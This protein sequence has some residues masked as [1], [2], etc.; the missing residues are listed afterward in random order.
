MK[1]NTQS[2][3][4][5]TSRFFMIGC[6]SFLSLAVSGCNLYEEGNLNSKKVQVQ[7]EA[8]SDDV[9]IALVDDAYIDALA[10]H[11]Y[12]YGGGEMNLA[13]TYDPHSNRNTAMRASEKAAEFAAKLRS[14]GVSNVKVG[15]VPVKDQ[16][17]ESRMM[18]SYMGYTAHAPE[19]CSEIPGMDGRALEYNPEYKLGCSMEAMIAQQIARPK[20]LLGQDNVDHKTDGR[21]A[22]NIVDIYRKGEQ[23]KP[24][25]GETASDEN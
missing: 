22:S 15:V 9:A 16:G 4:R 6:V 1:F 24:L 10:Y 18:V 21:A 2:M 25:E 20:D 17:A 11:Y 23:N 14:E 5:R 7:E 19:G 8:Y 3:P 13:V 12:K